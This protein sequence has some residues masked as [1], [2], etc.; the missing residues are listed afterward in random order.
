MASASAPAALS[1]FSE[2]SVWRMA[3]RSNAIVAPARSGS[4][5]AA[6][7]SATPTAAIHASTIVR[8]RVSSPGPKLGWSMTTTMVRL[9]SATGCVSPGAVGAV[10]EASAAAP[11]PR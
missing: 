11:G 3:A 6:I 9:G 4:D 10:D 8:A 2:A 1:G 7:W 5:T